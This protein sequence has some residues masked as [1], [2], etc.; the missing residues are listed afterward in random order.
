VP[1][2]ETLG[3]PVR[4]VQFGEG[5]FFRAFVAAFIQE[6]NDQGLF[7]GRI[8]AV[9]PMR[10]EGRVSRLPAH[11]CL[12]TLVARGLRDG[13]PVTDARVIGSVAEVIH[14]Y[15]EW[16]RLE[17]LFARPEVR[18][19]FSNTTEAGIRRDPEDPSSPPRSYPAKLEALLHVRYRALGSSS[20]TLYVIPCELIDDN[21]G[22]LREIVRELAQR[23]DPGF[24]GWLDARTRFCSSLVDRIAAGYPE[25]EAEEWA[26]RLGY[27]DPC[28]DAC[29]LSH[30]WAIENRG[31]PELE[32]LLPL[33]RAGIHAVFAPDIARYRLRKVRILNGAHTA[34]CAY[35]LVRGLRT[36]REAVADAGARS[37][38]EKAVFR[39][40][41]PA[42]ADGDEPEL[43]AYA[44]EVLERFANPFID[45][46]LT[47]IAANSSSKI[48]ARL[49]PTLAAYR[50]RFG[51]EP[52]ALVE[53]L[54]SFIGFMRVTRTCDGR[55]RNA[56]SHVLQD[57]P[58]F[59][60]RA[61]RL[62]ATEARSSESLAAGFRDALGLDPALDAGLARGLAELR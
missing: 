25:R 35:G 10:A 5:V 60:L 15:Q 33:A 38:L 34:L 61:E 44:R 17:A 57:D 54:A 26:A 31:A 9:Q 51:R 13:E 14:P 56:F 21:G 24:A 27:R 2:E 3:Y 22:A 32:E 37:M 28:L 55:F 47:A 43:Q 7:R 20:P 48:R 30:F 16:A 52:E 41:I 23:R 40:I 45:H 12:Y 11:D 29:E 6:M 1:A 49:S 36:V 50:A 4:A 62:W 18:F 42:I 58:A 39:E 19:V 53:A 46:Q 59:L 8:A